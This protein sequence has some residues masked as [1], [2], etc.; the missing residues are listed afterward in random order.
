MKTKLNQLW[1]FVVEI[2]A[3]LTVFVIYG[4]ILL[5]VHFLLKSQHV[6]LK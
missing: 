5:L 6:D 4:V 2:R 1:A 3:P